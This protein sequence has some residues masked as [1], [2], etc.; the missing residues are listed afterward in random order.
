MRRTLLISREIGFRG[1]EGLVLTN[2]RLLHR[3]GDDEAAS[4]HCQQAI[5]LT[6]E[7]G[8]RHIQAHALTFLGLATE[9]LAGLAS[10][11]LARGDLSRAQALVEEIL[12]YLADHTL[13]GTGEPFPIYLT[14]YRILRAS[15]DPL[16][17]EVLSSAYHLQQA[18]AGRIDDDAL[19]RS[20]LGNTAAC[21]AIMQEWAAM[22]SV[23]PEGGRGRAKG[24][25]PLR[26]AW[27]GL[28]LA[29]LKRPL[30]AQSFLSA[31]WVAW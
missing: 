27:A 25:N 2:L 12:G 11:A 19:R 8:E 28:V 7:I 31:L 26:L 6:R 30:R 3:L 21:R 23:R 20:F 17:Q 14:C 22:D 5:R 13:D 18:A 29:H 15:Q 24:V 4:E 16:S 10:V 9:S 1:L